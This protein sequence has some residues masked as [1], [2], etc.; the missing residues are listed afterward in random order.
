MQEPQ[1][2]PTFTLNEFRYWLNKNKEEQPKHKKPTKIHR[3][4]TNI[5]VES[6]LG[7]SRLSQKILE[8]NAQTLDQEQSDKLAKQF[9]EHGAEILVVEDLMAVVQVS[10]VKFNLPK[11]YTKRSEIK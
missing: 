11:M 10:D 4:E 1:R 6:R 8:H 3:D 5:K 2:E 7:V 9:K